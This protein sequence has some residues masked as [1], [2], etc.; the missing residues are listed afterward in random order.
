MGNKLKRRVIN[1]MNDPANRI[2]KLYDKFISEV[3]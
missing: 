2:V 1:R 3:N